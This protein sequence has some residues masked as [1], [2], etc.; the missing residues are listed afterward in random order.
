MFFLPKT[1]RNVTI[2]LIISGVIFLCMGLS[3]I[4]FILFVPSKFAFSFTLGSILLM[5]GIASYKGFKEFASS[6]LLKDRLPF[7]IAYILSLAA[8][9]YST[10]YGN[11]IYVL[12]SAMIQVDFLNLDI[13][14]VLAYFH[15]TSWWNWLYEIRDFKSISFSSFLFERIVQ[16]Q[17]EVLLAYLV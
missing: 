17:R 8:T 2:G 7:A 4:P 14:F 1:D 10:F 16:S 11:Y 12:I 13:Y 5:A 3:F 15:R 9:L 6:L